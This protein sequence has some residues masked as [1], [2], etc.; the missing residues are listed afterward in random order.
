MTEQNDIDVARLTVRPML[1]RD[2]D[3]VMVIECSSFGTP[4]SRQHFLDELAN[5]D[6]SVPLVM[7]DG[8][9][10]IA[11][12]VLWIILDE[13]H[14]A[15][16]AV[17]PAYRRKGIAGFFLNF[18]R[19]QAIERKC[20]RIMLEVR[21]SNHDAIRLYERFNYYRVGIRK[22]YYHDGFLRTED[23]ILMDLDLRKDGR[24]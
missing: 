18:I 14:L 22:N 3:E 16:I 8:K 15:N 10:I 12:A 21:K 24:E 9:K 19:G 4:W 7:D 2:L 17:S 6:I 20:S 1:F 11:Y 23:A 5:P 13:C